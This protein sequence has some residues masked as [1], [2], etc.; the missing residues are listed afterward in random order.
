ML[1]HRVP[2]E[3]IDLLPTRSAI[4]SRAPNLIKALIWRGEQITNKKQQKKNNP[5]IHSHLQ[6]NASPGRFLWL[7]SLILLPPLLRNSGP[8]NSSF[9]S[10]LTGSGFTTTTSAHKTDTNTRLSTHPCLQYLPNV[11][12]RARTFWYLFQIHR[13]VVGIVGD[14]LLLTFVCRLGLNYS[15]MLCDNSRFPERNGKNEN[16]NL[17]RQRSYY[18]RM[19]SNFLFAIFT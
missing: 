2:L 13:D 5:H 11:H 12:V 14:A 17:I 7:S 4:N 18:S 15:C 6:D 16:K 19:K 10:L 1:I 3:M 9:P 8:L